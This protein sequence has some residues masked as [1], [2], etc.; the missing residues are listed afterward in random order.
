MMLSREILTKMY[1]VGADIR[2]KFLPKTVQELRRHKE[3]E[4]AAK[5]ASPGLVGTIKGS[6]GGNQAQQPTG[7]QAV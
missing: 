7:H 3:E 5:A 6:H 2:K 1:A 4:K